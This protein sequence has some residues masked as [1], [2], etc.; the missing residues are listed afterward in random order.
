MPERFTESDY[1]FEQLATL[2]RNVSNRVRAVEPAAAAE[3]ADAHDRRA[4]RPAVPQHQ[5]FAAL[6][7]H[8][9]VA[10]LPPSV[11]CFNGCPSSSI[12]CFRCG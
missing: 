6:V 5:A 1:D 12:Q 2:A 10:K 9:I 4:D 11:S 3:P 8:R 7:P